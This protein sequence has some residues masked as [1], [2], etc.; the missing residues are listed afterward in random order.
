MPVF[1]QVCASSPPLSS[2]LPPTIGPAV[3]PTW[4]TGRPDCDQWM[5]QNIVDPTVFEQ[6]ASIGIPERRQIVQ[7]TM[8]KSTP[9]NHPD[10]WVLKCIQNVQSK[11]GSNAAPRPVA[12]PMQHQGAPSWVAPEPPQQQFVQ[13]AAEP[14]LVWQNSTV[15]SFSRVVPDAAAGCSVGSGGTALPPPVQF[16]GLASARQPSWV[17]S[18]MQ[19]LNAH[20]SVLRAVCPQLDGPV[21]KLFLSLSPSWQLKVATAV[22]ITPQAWENPSSQ[23]QL[24]LKLLPRECLPMSMSREVAVRS[25]SVLNVVLL[26][27][28][29][30]WGSGH[31]AVMAGVRVLKQLLPSVAIS[32]LEVFSFETD[33]DGIVVESALMKEMGVQGSQMGQVA[34]LPDLI[35]ERGQQWKAAGFFPVLFNSWPCE[36]TNRAAAVPD[37]PQGSGLHMQHSRAM[38]PIA[39]A[40]MMLARLMGPAGFCYLTEYPECGNLGEE[41]TLN[42]FFGQPF[43]NNPR[44]YNAA[45][46]PVRIRTSPLCAQVQQHHA[47]M[48]PSVPINGWVWCGNGEQGDN[49]AP[50]VILKSHL[51]H[52]TE[53]KVFGE[54]PLL[55]WEEV[56]L[57][58]CRMRNSDTGEIRLICRGFWLQWLGMAHSPVEKILGGLWPCLEFIHCASGMQAEASSAGEQCGTSRWCMNCERCFALHGQSWHLAGMADCFVAVLA[59]VIAKH[60]HKDDAVVFFETPDEQPHM[61]GPSCSSN[62]RLGE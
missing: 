62:P 15:S 22:L 60:V 47:V 11:S 46:R 17:Q 2:L 49:K 23:V 3:G 26:F 43:E 18:G 7:C 45:N 54:R 25:D 42:K 31:L 37:R 16:A 59:Q 10:K 27:N 21:L 55:D 4:S 24:M 9:I 20:S 1:P 13:G 34:A 8:R 28:C 12:S 51:T 53:V 40:Q 44:V 38:W 5:V 61:C 6:M 57:S 56:A 58:R 29:A 19:H 33:P 14:A 50:L 52:L 36:N 30:G 48:D 39:T 41:E 32:V 35:A